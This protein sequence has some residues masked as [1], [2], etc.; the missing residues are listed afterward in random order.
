[1]EWSRA[2]RYVRQIGHDVR[3]ETSHDHVVIV[4]AG[5]AFYAVLAILPALFLAVS[6]YGLFTNPVEAERQIDA[7]LEVLP[8]SS[9]MVLTEQMRIIA[10][11]NDA[12]L[13]IGFVASIAALTWTVSNL[14]RALVRAVKIAYDQE[15]ERSIL[16][17]RVVAIG[18]TLVVVFGVIVSLAVIA[19]VPIWL[20]RF[21]PTDAVVTFSNLRWILIGGLMAFGTGLLYRYAPP[22]R[23][24]HWYDVVPGVVLAVAI[25]TISSVGFSIY[26]SSFGRYNE[27]Y[28]A[29]GAAV[30]LL[31]WFWF[32]SIAVIL[33]AELNEA[34][35]LRPWSTSD[36]A[37]PAVDRH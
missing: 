16:E 13:S 36:E 3:V 5:V 31:L 12:G 20:Q 26:V 24:D 23:P 18:V 9:A 33:G 2:F 35:T 28:G 10:E 15:T 37:E 1:M 22:R 25:W 14:T 8:E 19:A 11:T 32:S 4:A 27:T 7:L 21:D 17:N 29:L 6:A 34:L 30:V